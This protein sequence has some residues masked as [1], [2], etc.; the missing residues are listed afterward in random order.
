VGDTCHTPGIP[1][2]TGEESETDR[3]GLDCE[4]PAGTG[5][6]GNEDEEVEEVENGGDGEDGEDRQSIAS[7]DFEE[8][9]ACR[10]RAYVESFFGRLL[11]TDIETGDRG[12]LPTPSAAG[13]CGV[14]D[15]YRD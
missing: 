7:D 9:T 1:C 8:R 3:K 12:P 6:G 5:G 14:S 10:T 13:I 4:L 2:H 15:T 11:T